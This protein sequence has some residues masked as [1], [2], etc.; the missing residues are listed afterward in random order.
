[1]AD[2]TD[3]LRLVS[4]DKCF[5]DVSVLQQISLSVAS[6]EF[7]TILG[8]SGSGK[9]TILRLIGGFE[10]PTSGRIFLG[11]T[12]I[13]ETPINQRPFNT[14]FQD[15]ALFPHLSVRRNVGY[16]LMVRHTPRDVI[17]RRVNDVL[18]IVGLESLASRLPHELS[19]GQR[20]R[21]ALAR[22]II[23]EP[24]IILLDEPLAALDVALRAQMCA[25]LK[26]LQ[27]RLE[28][29]FVFITHDQQEAIAMSDRIIVMNAGHIEQSGAPQDL[30]FNP[31]SRFVADFFGENNII[32]GRL[33]DAA[34]EF[35]TVKTAL[36]KVPGRLS[37]AGSA[38]GD[39]MHVAIRPEHV[40]LVGDT[41][42]G[43]RFIVQ[44]VQF[45]GFSTSLDAIDESSRSIGMRLRLPNSGVGRLPSK[46][47][48]ISLNWLPEHATVMRADTRG[49]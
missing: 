25:F 45:A 27:R 9:T 8:P 6:N 13:T 10:Q 15:Y 28:I 36:G 39:P 21:V 42:A 16:G 29:A 31:K 5:G 24:R 43:H 22:A 40:R 47:E 41:E 12:D 7:L 11:P 30:Y 38:S 32:D 1:M 35:G 48:T 46:G 49:R 2:H 3:F 34:G 37:A 14:V 44:D 19:G 18:S 26:G 4:V 23:C 33:V 20:Q 17:D